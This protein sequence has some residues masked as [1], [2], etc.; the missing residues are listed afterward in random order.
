MGSGLGGVPESERPALAKDQLFLLRGLILVV[1]QELPMQVHGLHCHV[2][3]QGG[4]HHRA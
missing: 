1:W 2:L 3:R 4:V